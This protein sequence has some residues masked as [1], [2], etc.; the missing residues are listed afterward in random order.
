VDELK[1]IS[2]SKLRL[3]AEVG[4]GPQ[5]DP[6]NTVTLRVSNDGGKTWGFEYSKPLGNTGEN[7]QIVEWRALGRSMRRAFEISTT[8]KAPVAWV[9]AF[10]DVKEGR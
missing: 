10:I 7:T 6:N 4:N 9:D 1:V 3:S 2:Y 5:D 8:I